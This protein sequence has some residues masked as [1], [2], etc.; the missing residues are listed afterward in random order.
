MSIASQ[1]KDQLNN[2]ER[3]FDAREK[4]AARIRMREVD[5]EQAAPRPPVDVE[6]LAHVANT[7]RKR[8]CFPNGEK[9]PTWQTRRVARKAF[10]LQRQASKIRRTAAPVVSHEE[11]KYYLRLSNG[12]RIQYHSFHANPTLNVLVDTHLKSLANV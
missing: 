6:S 5:S 9:K 2:T 4:T 11:G 7:F 1:L 3:C 10:Q 8:G 12:Q